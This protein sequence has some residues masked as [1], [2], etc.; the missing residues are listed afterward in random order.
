MVDGKS[1]EYNIPQTKLFPP[2]QQDDGASSPSSL[3]VPDTS[4]PLEQ[5]ALHYFRE[6]TIADLSGFTTYTRAFWNSVIPGLSQAEPA[7]RHIAIALASQHEAQR[8]DPEK[9]EELSRFCFKHHSLA[10]HNLSRSSPAQKEEVLLVSCIAFI[11]FERFR[12]PDGVH[13][14]YLDYAIA[15]LKILREREEMR[16]RTGNGGAF[17]LVDDFVEPML[18]QIE[19]IFTMFCEPDRVM[20]NEVSEVNSEPPNFPA[21]FVD[22][23]SACNA[24][25]RIILWRYI[26]LHRNEAWTNTS[27]GFLTVRNL[28][29]KWYRALSALQANVPDNEVEQYH[30]IEALRKQ[31]RVLSGAILYSV[32]EDI[33]GKTLCRPT[34]AYLSLPD[35]LTIFTGIDRNRKV[36]L[37]GMNGTLYPWPHAKRVGGPD[38]DSFVALEFTASGMAV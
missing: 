22:I 3:Q 26:V 16:L 2:P 11:A 19:I 7:I 37:S 38:G 14:N 36:N 32:R 25:F 4:D 21:E 12:D 18:F 13:G 5:R 31:I 35:K 10:L 28:M 24:V 8:S 6:K 1:C 23:P 9:R 20:L 27:C 34:L 33:P 15:G 17:N 30:R 29:E